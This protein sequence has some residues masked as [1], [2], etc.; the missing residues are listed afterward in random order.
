M[1]FFQ[2]PACD[3]DDAVPL[4]KWRANCTMHIAMILHSTG[5]RHA[6]LSKI[7]IDDCFDFE[8]A[9]CIDRQEFVFEAVCLC[10]MLVWIELVIL[11]IVIDVTF[12]FI[13]PTSIVIYA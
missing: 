10:M 7:V 8:R 5:A 11:I 13:C 6:Q 1:F 9:I 12:E 2:F 3:S 4:P